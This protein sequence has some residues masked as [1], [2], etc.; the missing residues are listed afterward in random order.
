MQN[1]PKAK[2]YISLFP[3]EVRQGESI[4]PASDQTNAEREEIRALIQ[5]Q[6]NNGTLSQEPELNIELSKVKQESALPRKAPKSTVTNDVEED[7][8]FENDEDE[9]S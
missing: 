6:M 5:E 3:P 4:A 2:K 8:F 9:S 1:Y 7:E